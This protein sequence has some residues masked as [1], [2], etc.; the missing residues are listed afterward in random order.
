MKI[1]Y[2]SISDILSPKEMKNVLGGSGY[3]ICV[4]DHTSYTIP[5]VTSCDDVNCNEKCD[6]YGGYCY[7]PQGSN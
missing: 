4:C 3:V 5:S 2:K 7:E 6:T 1:S